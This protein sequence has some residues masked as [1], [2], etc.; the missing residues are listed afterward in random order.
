MI[1]VNFQIEKKRKIVGRKSQIYI[2]VRRIY[3]NV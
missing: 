3:Q 2:L 1:K